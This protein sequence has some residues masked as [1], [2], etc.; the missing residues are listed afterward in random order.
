LLATAGPQPTVAEENRGAGTRAW[1]LPGPPSDV[2]GLAHGSI[3]GY[4][5]RQAVRPG[6]LERIYVST[7]GTGHVRIRIFRI[8]WYGGAGGREVLV[9]Q[10]LRAMTQPPCTHRSATGLTECRWRPTLSFR[11][12]SALPTGV[13]IVKLSASTGERDCLFVVRSS[14]TQPLLAQLPT[15]T[16]E[17]YNAWG[18]DSLYPGGSDRVGVTGTTQGIDVSYQRPYDSVTGAGQFFARDVAMVW[19]LERYRYPVS[20][21][22]SE[23]DDADPGQLQGHRALI[24]FGHS[25]YWSQRQADGFARARDAGTSLLF[26]GSDTLAWRVRYAPASAAATQAGQTDQSIVAYKE[27]VSLDPNRADPT[28]PFPDRGATLTGN[29]Y[30]GCITPRLPSAGPP[31]YRYYSWSPSPTLEPRWLFSNTGVTAATHIPGIVGYELDQ[32]TSSS[33]PDIQTVGGGAAPCM[34]PE[35]GEPVPGP[36][37]NHAE[38]TLFTARS[39]AVVFDTGTLGWELGL[40]PVPSASPDA[41]LSPDPRIVAI[42]RNVL[43]RALGGRARGGH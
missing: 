35:P 39:G 43:G 40:E 23:S 3:V 38:T 30:L 19:F 8:G 10:R 14:Q 9:S 31:T 32:R 25:E 26:F 27:H 13:Y 42:T 33:P 4:V 11:I 18:G 16:Y 21:T 17:A 2:G 28:G 20:Y 15:A 7:P 22:T 6:D 5:S 24:D 1:R 37:Q 29:A 36:G 34:R 41:P 12:P